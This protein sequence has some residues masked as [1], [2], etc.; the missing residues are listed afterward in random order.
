VLVTKRDREQVALALEVD[1]LSA[2]AR[3]QNE[4]QRFV[5]GPFDMSLLVSYDEH[6]AL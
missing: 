1:V 3:K 6:V 5:G 4:Q 2:P